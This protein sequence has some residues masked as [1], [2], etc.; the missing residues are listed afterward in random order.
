MRNVSGLSW[1]PFFCLVFLTPDHGL[2]HL[3]SSFFF[4]EVIFQ[5]GYS[6]HLGLTLLRIVRTSL[7]G[8]KLS[9]SARKINF[10]LIPVF[11]YLFHFPVSSH[12]YSIEHSN[13][14]LHTQLHIVGV[15]WF[16]S[17]PQC[18][19]RMPYEYDFSR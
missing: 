19:S 1:R 7:R 17:H 16:N 2:T 6:S 11:L 5:T 18:F 13:D 9:F 12:P 3:S 14:N 10:I 4:L 8:K 15:K